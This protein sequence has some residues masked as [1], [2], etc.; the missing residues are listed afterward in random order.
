MCTLGSPTQPLLDPLLD[1]P[2]VAP[3]VDIVIARPMLAA[4]PQ[5][6]CLQRRIR[7]LRHEYSACTVAAGGNLVRCYTPAD[8]AGSSQSL[9]ATLPLAM[10]CVP[11]RMST[12]ATIDFSGSRERP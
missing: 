3:R 4:H 11:I 5:G 6:R 1:S 7:L 10:G 12:V 2:S 9:P 8:G